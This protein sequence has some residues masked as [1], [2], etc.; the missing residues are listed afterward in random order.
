MKL[1]KK[2]IISYFHFLYL[3]I[4]NKFFTHFPSYFLRKFIL[5]Y[6][7]KMRIGRYSN[8]Q[9]GVR[10]YSPW[11]IKIG[12]NCSIGYNSLL[13]GRRSILIGNNVDLAGEIKIM[14]LGHDLND[15]YYKTVGK[16][17][18]IEDNVSVFMGASILPG[19]II[20]EGSIIAL[21]SVVTKD[22][23][24]WCIYGGNPAKKIGERKINYLK[25]QR[26]YK[27]YFH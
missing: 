2:T 27:R 1:L 19:R 13:D 20:R 25:Y 3:S 24:P 8:V 9:M 14:T 23:D 26:N 12:N 18:I 7:Y 16:K 15:P 5:K 17:V 6:F 11:K 10:V 4:Y 22:T 21:A